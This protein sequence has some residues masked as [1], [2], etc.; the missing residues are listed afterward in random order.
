MKLCISHGLKFGAQVFV[1]FF[2]LFY[3]YIYI[4][5]IET[6]RLTKSSRSIGSKLYR[7]RR[8]LAINLTSEIPSRTTNTAKCANY[9]AHFNRPSP[10]SH[11]HRENFA[12]V[13]RKRVTV[14]YEGNPRILTGAIGNNIPGLSPP[15]SQPRPLPVVTN[16]SN[17]ASGVGKR[18]VL[19]SFSVPR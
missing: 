14:H 16:W 9:E 1:V 5:K 10:R 15:S 18:R 8:R 11:Q 3:I 7:E 12:V 6:H 13:F 17:I 2:F 19:P 4:T